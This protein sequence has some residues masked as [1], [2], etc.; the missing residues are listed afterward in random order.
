MHKN[1]DGQAPFVT[2]GFPKAPVAASTRE[3][4]GLAATRIIL[5]RS[6]E[7]E[8][9]LD[10]CKHMKLDNT[11]PSFTTPKSTARY[12]PYWKSNAILEKLH[13]IETTFTHDKQT[14]TT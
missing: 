7:K 11:A 10:N 2:M 6:C 4:R 8:R 1:Q 13:Y 14:F 12:I 9:K 5:A 3:Q